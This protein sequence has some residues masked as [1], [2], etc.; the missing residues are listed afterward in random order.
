MPSPPHALVLGAGPTGSLL[1][2]A[3]AH[4][5]WTVRL[6]D[7]LS[8]AQLQD[9]QRAYALTHSTRRLLRRLGLWER[10]EP[11]LTPF[12]SL[13]LADLGCDRELAFLPGDLGESAAGASSSAAAIGWIVQHQALMARL[14][15]QLEATAAIRTCLGQES[16]STPPPAARE[17]EADA[18]FACDGPSSPTRQS[19]GVGCWQWVYRQACLTVQVRLR[20]CPDD[21]AME[22][23]RPEGPFAVLPLGKGLFQLVW[24]A[25]LQRCRALEQLS[26]AAFLDRLAG[27][28]PDGLQPEA[29]LTPPRAFPVALQLSR[30]LQRG[31]TLLVGESAH[32]C[33]PVGGQG[34]NLCWRDI[35]ALLPLAERV[36][37]GRLAA[38]RLGGAYARR[39]WPDLL[40]TL[41]ATDLLVRLFSNRAALLLPPRQLALGLLGRSQ[42]LR[43]LALAV[44]SQGPCWPLRHGAA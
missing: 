8:P 37:A 15:G 19:L 23:L 43:R 31:R 26:P 27:A 25:P 40:L 2:L 29:L 16:P 36:A 14:L 12:R 1:A 20:G 7:P 38:S 6:Q 22:L 32:R 18:V 42:G 9:R 41:L 10:L 3:L 17:A 11:C 30:R 5:G 13:Q 24:S 39:R 34:L 28:L 33:H 44:M 4:C 21:T 35:E